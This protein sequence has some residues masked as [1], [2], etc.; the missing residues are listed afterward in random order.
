MTFADEFAQLNGHFFFRQFTYSKGTFR[1]TPTDEVELSDNLLWL[2]DVVVAF[3]LKERDAVPN[4][5]QES[6]ARWLARKVVTRGTRQVRDTLEYLRAHEVIELQ[7]NQGDRFGLKS[8][9]IKSI[10]KVVCYAPHPLFARDS[11]LKKYHRSQSAGAIH[12]IAAQDYLGIVRTL[13]T[14]AEFCDYL[15]FR[16]E[17]IGRWGVAI[18][19]VSEIAL[20][21]Q[22]ISGD[23]E[24]RPDQ[25]FAEIV[26]SL[27]HR[28]EEWDMSG[29]IK[30]FPVRLLAAHAGNEYYK[31]VGEIA[32]L[33]RNELREFRERFELSMRTCRSGK[34]VTPYRF[35]S[36]RT[37]CAFLFIPLSPEF[38]DQR[39][40]G[41]QNSDNG[42]QV[43]PENREMSWCVLRSRERWVVCA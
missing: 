3:Q 34:F 19:E 28:I 20:L 39:R 11:A 13:I 24:L 8:S 5:T 30:L 37:G 43:R 4:A 22:Y 1:P 18:N 29:V 26:W 23:A 42:L 12:L 15:S 7:N 35:A 27:N 31:I 10:H 2:G 9:T 38:R 25:S 6:E 17:L 41:L 14:P 16:E 36:V 21:G 33:K 40:Q 32:K